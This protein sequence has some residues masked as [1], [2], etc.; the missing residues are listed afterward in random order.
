[1]ELEYVA[2]TKEWIELT[3]SFKNEK[4][5]LS[6]FKLLNDI[7]KENIKDVIKQ[8]NSG[9]FTTPSSPLVKKLNKKITQIFH[10]FDCIKSTID[11][12]FCT[13]EVE[14]IN[15]AIELYIKHKKKITLEWQF[16]FLPDILSA[17][18]KLKIKINNFKSICF[19]LFAGKKIAPNIEPPKNFFIENTKKEIIF[20][21]K[22]INST[23]F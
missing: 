5:Y 19:K 12:L 6:F 3:S 22:A 14:N 10:H 20:L 4:A 7:K 17:L 15:Q 21:I 16:S 8:R 11:I 1:M 2:Q 9:R 23:N 13:G 18:P